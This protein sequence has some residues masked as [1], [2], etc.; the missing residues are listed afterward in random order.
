[1]KFTARLHY[2]SLVLLVAPRLVTAQGANCSSITGTC[3]YNSSGSTVCLVNS[4]K[5]SNVTYKWD[6]SAACT[7]TRCPTPSAYI[8]NPSTGLLQATGQCGTLDPTTGN[9]IPGGKSCPPMLYTGG[10]SETTN[11]NVYT[12]QAQNFTQNTEGTVCIAGAAA[13]FTASCPK[14]ICSTGGS[15]GTVGGGINS[16]CESD[17]NCT[18]G[19]FCDT[20]RTPAVCWPGSPLLVDIDGDGFAMTSASS[21]VPFDLMG[22]GRKP[23]ISWTAR[24]SDD[25][26]LALDRNGNG[27]IDSG[28]ELFGNYTPQPAG[29]EQNGFEALAVHDLPANG[30]NG[31]GEI[32]VGDTVFAKLR[33]WVDRNHNGFSEASELLTL[34]QG[35]VKAFDLKYKKSRF[36]DEHGNEFRYRARIVPVHGTPTGKWVYDV[37]LN[38]GQ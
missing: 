33:L 4:G 29:P 27:V 26:W 7:D 17:F 2:A 10:T 37:Y 36:V 12:Q 21:G 38:R 14:R 31:D 22:S 28:R 35:G 20:G 1:M 11:N 34:A 6:C 32:D 15:C 8:A 30:G 16:P 18:P 5:G 13:T 9:P 23:Q 19:Y 3:D 25:A 24:N